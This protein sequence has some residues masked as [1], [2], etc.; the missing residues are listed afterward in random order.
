M[1]RRRG[2]EDKAR[3]RKE[4][5]EMS[6]A[7]LNRRTPPEWIS[8]YFYAT[9]N[10]RYMCLYSIIPLENSLEVFLHHNPMQSN[11]KNGPRN[12]HCVCKRPKKS[13][14]RRAHSKQILPFWRIPRCNHTKPQGNPEKPNNLVPGRCRG[15]R[16]ALYNKPTENSLNGNFNQNAQAGYSEELHRPGVRNVG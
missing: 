2:K 7:G 5:R 1:G 9:I 4:E 8:I 16:L 13:S 10:S 12:A 3:E 15:R 11:Q 6:L 14:R